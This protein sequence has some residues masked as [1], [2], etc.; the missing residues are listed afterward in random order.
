MVSREGG[1][2]NH[3]RNIVEGLPS[4][5]KGL[6]IN[7]EILLGLISLGFVVGIIIAIVQ[8]YGKKCFVW[9]AV[10]YEWFF[11]GVPEL[12]LILLV[13]FGLRQFGV[14][15][16]AFFAAT[17]ALGLRSSAYQSQ[18]FRGAIQAVGHGQMLAALSLGMTR[19]QAIRY[20]ILPQALRLAIPPWSNEFSSVLKDTTLAYAI[21][22]EEILRRA[23]YLRMRDYLIT[24]PVF[25]IV[26]LL[27]LVLTYAG[28]WTLERLERRFRIPGFEVKG[29]REERL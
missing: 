14:K 23:N 13:F 2:I 19:I 10:A 7:V 9:P 27:F 28:N 8:V 4:L 1:A 12:V 21:G 5:L 24:I 26:A 20:V 11:R 17:L 3:W 25:I 16:T 6:G 29:A 18:I 22:V 15:I